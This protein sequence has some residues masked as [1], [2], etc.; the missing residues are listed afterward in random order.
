MRKPWCHPA[1]RIL[2]KSS[3]SLTLEIPGASL[4]NYISFLMLLLIQKKGQKRMARPLSR[5]TRLQKM[6][7]FVNSAS[8]N[9][10]IVKRSWT[11]LLI[12][13][14][15]MSQLVKFILQKRDYYLCLKIK[16]K[17]WCIWFMS[18]VFFNDRFIII[19]NFMLFY[20]MSFHQN[21]VK[22]FCRNRTT[23]LIVKKWTVF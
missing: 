16:G 4:Y 2:F 11:S 10:F 19:F 7:K 13:L 23:A 22:V 17:Q 1:I 3:F 18:I 12:H 9:K 20:W 8:F 14:M 21:R 15:D 6:K 5:M